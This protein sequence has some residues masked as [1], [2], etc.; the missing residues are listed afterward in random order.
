MSM[1]KLTASGFSIFLVATDL[2]L[3]P[4]LTHSPAQISQ[5]MADR[6]RSTNPFI[7]I[8]CSLPCRVVQQEVVEVVPHLEVALPHPRRI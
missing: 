1:N 2:I 6:V 3:T 4:P 8:I 5:L 7:P